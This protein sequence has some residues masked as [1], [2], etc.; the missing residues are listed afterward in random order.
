[1]SVF[2]SHDSED[3][4]IA[5]RLEADLADAGIGVWI[6]HAGIRVGQPLAD[7]IQQALRAADCLVLLWSARSAESRY[8]KFEWQAA[9]HIAKPVIPCSLDDT[10]VPL[11]L[12]TVL[13]CDFR[14]YET[15][16]A[17]L[18]EALG[19]SGPVRPEAPKPPQPKPE[20]NQLVHQLHR[21]QSRV[22]ATLF[23]QGPAPASAI[24]KSVDPLIEQALE[25]GPRDPTAL[26]FAGY[27][28]KN[29]YMI[30]HWDAV[31]N[32]SAPD[33]D[34]LDEAERYF[35][36]TLAIHP[37]DPSA[38]NGLGSVLS[39]RRDL[40]ASEFFIQRALEILPD[41]EAA[42]QDLKIVQALKQHQRGGSE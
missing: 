39:L 8:V 33:D 34:L 10:A 23:K 7:T 14:R 19:G 37:D 24:Q 20:L 31:Q 3:K 16:L 38:L 32:W 35:Y 5:R 28:K 22:L 17:R 29:A 6:D 15:G 4:T 21:G 30:A 13:I 11:F 40:D 41:Y 1:M 42:Q 36:E 12:Q 27:H 26:S 25:L 18:V 9:V 2:I